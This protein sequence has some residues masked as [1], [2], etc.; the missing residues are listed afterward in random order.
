M[1][2]Q[3]GCGIAI[4]TSSFYTDEDN[5]YLFAIICF[6]SQICIVAQDISLD[7]LVIKELKSPR[8]AGIVQ[9]YGQTV[10]VTLGGLILLKLTSK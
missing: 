6:A 9:A 1:M 5:A 3:T 4:L 10:G 8:Q 7:A 2:S